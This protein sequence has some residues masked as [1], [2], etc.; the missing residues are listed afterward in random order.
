[1]RGDS[2]S[3]GRKVVGTRH[4]HHLTKKQV[5]A[6]FAGKAAQAAARRS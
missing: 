1:M 2:P 3:P 5:L 6:G 4:G